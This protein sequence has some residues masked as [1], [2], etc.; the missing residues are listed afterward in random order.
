MSPATTRALRRALL[1]LAIGVIAAV[2][3]T[4]RR[5]EPRRAPSP[6]AAPALRSAK[7]ETRTTGLV[8]R[9]FKQ[10]DQSFVVEA[11]TSVGREETG[12]RLGGVKLTFNYTARGRRGTS[13]ITSDECTY[14][15][16]TP[17]ALFQGHVVLTTDDGFELTKIGR[18]HV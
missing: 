18:A 16:K 2:A 1:G 3:W 17:R 5:P 14:E 10:G 4:L 8:F 6:E 13:V 9:S 12:F 7:D 15:P 11:E